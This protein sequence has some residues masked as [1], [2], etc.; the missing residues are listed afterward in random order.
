MENHAR[1]ARHHRFLFT[2]YRGTS[3]GVFRQRFT[4]PLRQSGS[5]SGLEA[6]PLAGVKEDI[7]LDFLKF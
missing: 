5:Q 3:V 1:N 6:M 7:K 2:F 4:Q